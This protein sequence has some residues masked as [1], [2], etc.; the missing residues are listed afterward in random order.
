[1]GYADSVTQILLRRGEAEQ[2]AELD[3]GN[4]WAGMAQQ[5][6]QIPAQV[7]AHREQQADQQQRRELQ[8]QQIAGNKALEAQR[9]KDVADKEELTKQ[10]AALRS[11]F[12]DLG[13][14]DPDLKKVS[15]IVG[16][17]RGVK[18][19]DGMINFR[20]LQRG[21]Y[22]NV[23]TVTQKVLQGFSAS[24]DAQRKAAY[25]HIK[26]ELIKAGVMQPGDAP[27]VY[28]PQWYAS[29]VA[30]GKEQ[31]KIAT[32]EIK[33][34]NAD[35]SETIRIVKDEPTA[36]P[37]ESAPPAITPE[38]QA[39]NARADAAAVETARHNHAT[40]AA[41]ARSAANAGSNRAP[42]WVNRGGK[43]IRVSEAQYREGDLPASTREQGRSVTSGDAGDLAD[44]D[45]SL[46]DLK[47]LRSTIAPRDPKTGALIEAGATGTTAKIGA[48]LPNAVTDATG[49]GT[50]A[51]Q[52][53][54]VID[55]V[56]QVIGKTLEGGVLRK[57]DE[58]KYEKI[59]PTIADTVA[60]VEAKLDGLDAAITKRRQRRIDA[61]TDAN[62]DTSKFTA[63]PP[64]AATGGKITVKAPDGSS[65]DFA[66]QAE[67]DAFKKLAGI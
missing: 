18:I 1:M 27:D 52:K 13:D 55:R 19:A 48:W 47:V 59:L 66:T 46:D 64:R 45:T 20:K 42:F 67:A 11:Y 53:Q 57:E 56:K 31:A 41:A 9:V 34:R 22:D 24:T 35:G 54:A 5:L 4:A 63:R 33:T 43:M 15:A 49:I 12:A 61:L 29:R 23:Q 26:D 21:D 36:T 2:R 65:H 62:Y 14:K 16:P 50:V 60:V 17:E 10:D 7:I 8:Q 6:G 39:T 38:Q 32:R 28:D 25:P 44:F 30:Y 40:E 51:K 58:A 3:K 37:F